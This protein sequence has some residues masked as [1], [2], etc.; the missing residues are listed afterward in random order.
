[1]ENTRLTLCHRYSF[2][3]RAA[4]Q[5][6]RLQEGEERDAGGKE[7]KARMKPPSLSSK[8]SEE[9]PNFGTVCQ[10]WRMLP[11]E[12][13]THRWFECRKKWWDFKQSPSERP[14]IRRQHGFS[15]RLFITRLK[16][17]WCC[18]L[19]HFLKINN[20]TFSFTVKPKKIYSGPHSLSLIRLKKPWAKQNLSQ[21]VLIELNR[22]V[23]FCIVL[24][25]TGLSWAMSLSEIPACM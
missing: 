23:L 6:G 7:T 2:I 5:K 11:I 21:I 9:P 3:G 13:S 19:V 12:H 17:I 1:M 18:C 25:W 16:V 15:H 14:F 8:H 10:L 4:A 24:I 20:L 22:I